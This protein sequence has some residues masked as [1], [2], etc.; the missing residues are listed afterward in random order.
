[1]RNRTRLYH[2]PSARA[3]GT[4]I[5]SMHP[6]GSY[7]MNKIGR[8]GCHGPPGLDAKQVDPDGHYP[9]KAMLFNFD[10]KG[11]E[12]A[13]GWSDEANTIWFQTERKK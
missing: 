2:D 4:H 5:L 1:M 10:V 8:R 7:L 6:E 11:K 9:I 12:S 3:D 13:A